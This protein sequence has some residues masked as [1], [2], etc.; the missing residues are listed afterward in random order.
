MA[1]AAER[2]DAFLGGSERFEGEEIKRADNL[3]MDDN[4]HADTGFDTGAAGDRSANA[5]VD[6]GQI[7]N[8]HEV[9]RSPGAAGKALAFFKGGFES[10]FL[11]LVIDG[12]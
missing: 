10:D 4:G 9:T 6:L 12:A 8:K 2:F 1:D 11:E 5:I 7:G 3:V